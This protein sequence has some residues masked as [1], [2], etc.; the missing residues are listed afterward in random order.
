MSAG[1]RRRR[2]RNASAAAVGRSA[3]V[4]GEK[5]VTASRRR[6][7]RAPRRACRGTSGRRADRHRRDRRRAISRGSIGCAARIIPPSAT[8]CPRTSPCSTRLPPSA[9]A[10][11]AHEP[12]ADRSPRPPPRASIEGLMDLGGGVAFRIV[13]PDLDR[14]RARARRATFTAC[15]AR[16]T[17]A[18]GGRTSPSRTR[19]PPK[20]ARALHRGARARLPPAAAR[21]SAGLACTA[22]SAGRGSGLR[23]IRFAGAR[24]RR[25][26][27][28]QLRSNAARP[29]FE[30]RGEHRLLHQFVDRALGALADEILRFRHRLVPVARPRR[31]PGRPS[32][33]RSLRRAGPRRD[34]RTP[35]EALP[36]RCR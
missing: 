30:H 35:P 21:R 14:I 2:R 3:T 34:P 1:R 17:R 26:S 20:D 19:S 25:R 27:P 9:E 5:L 13:S 7:I 31:C 29:G 4:E 12:R 6:A 11:S 36:R 24:R 28:S 16:R 33:R 15:S 18:A 23:R 10:R 22:I 32:R 8:S